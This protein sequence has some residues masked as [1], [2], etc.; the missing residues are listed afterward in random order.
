MLN[1]DF[2]GSQFCQKSVECQ[3][4]YWLLHKTS[5][6]LAK[7][8]TFELSISSIVCPACTAP[9]EKCLKQYNGVQN[10]RVNVLSKK[11]T[12]TL[13]KDDSNIDDATELKNAIAEIGHVCEECVEIKSATVNPAKEYRRSRESIRRC[14]MKGIIGF[15]FGIGLLL[16]SI[17][18]DRV[19]KNWVN[20][21]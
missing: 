15:L 6:R 3:I 9:I 19:L 8:R 18:K 12:I 5:Y 2:R 11:A 1:N 4:K 10:V 17:D 14:L 13:S 16:L 20:A 7:M 21:C